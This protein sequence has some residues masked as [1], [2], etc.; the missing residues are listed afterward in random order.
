MRPYTRA[1]SEVHYR[2]TNSFV[3]GDEAV[4]LAQSVPNSF[5]AMVL[6]RRRAVEISGTRSYQR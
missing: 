6:Q 5:I 1:R 4:L 3:K 2:V